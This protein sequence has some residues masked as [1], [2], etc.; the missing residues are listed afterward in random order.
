MY[1][2]NKIN[3]ANISS[4]NLSKPKPASI[5]LINQFNNYSNEQ[6]KY[7]CCVPLP[8]KSGSCRVRYS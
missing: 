3:Q 5:N 2:T 1:T 8:F 4:K 6:N 7:S